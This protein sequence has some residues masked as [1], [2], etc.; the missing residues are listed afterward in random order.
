MYASVSAQRTLVAACQPTKGKM[1]ENAAPVFHMSI[2]L[3]DDH[4]Q[5][6]MA[7]AISAEP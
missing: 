2:V 4:D 7:G 5:K 3:T 6:Q 1:F